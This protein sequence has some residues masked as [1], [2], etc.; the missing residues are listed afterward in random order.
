MALYIPASRRRRQT[1]LV[2]VAA[3][4]LGL[5]VGGAIG[6]A[7]APSIDDRIRSVRSDARATA[8]ALRVLALHD[9]SGAA[10]NQA[11]GGGADLVLR[12]TRAELRTEFARAP[13]LRASQRSPL[14]A[15]LDR[16]A[17][18]PDHTSAAFGAAAETFAAHIEATF[19]VD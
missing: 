4:L 6:R 17:A 3:L 2:A 16:L 15:E 12:R 9:Q 5:L 10:S 8:A 7:S 1:V 18:Q 14:L 13:W 19:G 11:N